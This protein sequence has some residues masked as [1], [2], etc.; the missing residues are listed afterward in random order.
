[1]NLLEIAKARPG[2]VITAASIVA[3]LGGTAVIELPADRK[4][5]ALEVQ[6][7]QTWQQREAWQQQQQ[8]YHRD[9]EIEEI[10]WRL[11]YIS[12]E[13]NRISQIP[14]YLNRNLSPEEGWQIE[15]LKQEYSLLQERRERLSNKR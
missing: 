8:I 6:V 13:I 15:Q 11:R 7:A 4:V 1:M 3:I 10:D 12:A 2:T 5:K 14:R 9:R